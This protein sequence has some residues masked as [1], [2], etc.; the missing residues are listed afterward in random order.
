M[1]VEM[2][3]QG[4]DVIGVALA[5]LAGDLRC[6][7]RIGHDGSFIGNRSPMIQRLRMR[8]MWQMFF[9]KICRRFSE[10]GHAL[11][12]L[13]AGPYPSSF[14]SFPLAMSVTLRV[15]REIAV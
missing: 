5:Q 13:G 1:L 4:D 12:I 11:A 6:I 10:L 9:G 8:M 3:P 15:A 14:V 7:V 2:A